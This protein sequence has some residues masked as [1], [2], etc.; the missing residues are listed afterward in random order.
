[1]FSVHSR[2]RTLQCSLWA[3][4]LSLWQRGEY[5][6][7]Q[8]VA[9]DH[10]RCPRHGFGVCQLV[11]VRHAPVQPRFRMDQPVPGL[12]ELSSLL[13][14]LLFHQSLIL[15]TSQ[16]RYSLSGSWSGFLQPASFFFEE[17][18]NICSDTALPLSRYFLQCLEHTPGA[19]TVSH[20][21]CG[22][23]IQTAQKRD[24]KGW[25]PAGQKVLLCIALLFLCVH[26]FITSEYNSFPYKT[27]LC[28]YQI[29][30]IP[31]CR[32]GK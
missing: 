23:H 5:A 11:P 12:R 6:T 14:S 9:W 13:L 8:A 28:L 1:M 3:A 24:L 22:Y 19:K 4:R 20:Q 15:A 29:K 7:A 31:S 30:P 17:T 2:T 25:D 32:V 18:G 10:C 27:I 21:T 26:Q 16:I